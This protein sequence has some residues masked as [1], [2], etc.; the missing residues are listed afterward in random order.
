MLRK[1]KNFPCVPSFRV[2]RIEKLPLINRSSVKIEGRC[3]VAEGAG[4]RIGR[5][6]VKSRGISQKSRDPGLNR[7]HMFAE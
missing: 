6:G 4:V 3:V 7:G 2:F 5:R 1:E